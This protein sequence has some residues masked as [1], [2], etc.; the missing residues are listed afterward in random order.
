MSQSGDLQEFRQYL[1]GVLPEDGLRRL[2]ERLLTD[3]D[4]YAELLASEDE[5]VDEYLGGALSADEREKFERHFL[6]TPE[7]RRKLSFGTA[8]RRYA[9]EHHAEASEDFAEA[10]LSST[11]D[12]PTPAPTFGER[13]RAFW[14][15]QAVGLRFAAALLLAAFAVGAWWLARTPA[16]RTFAT[17]TLA[18][19]TGDRAA[20]AEPVKVKLR[21][22]E[23]RVVLTLPEGATAAGYRAELLRDGDK[24]SP[25][26]VN[27]SDARSVLVA[28]PADRLPPGSYA[29]RLYATDGGGRHVGTYLFNVE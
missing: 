20:G 18:A 3:E 26:N 12:A 16:E 10:P 22:D 14:G 27:V 29:L 24:P 7:R 4:F 11:A 23:L 21:E 28:I 13:L 15:S 9:S 19:R 2:E 8:L 5:L 1:L 17:L 25:V 6:C